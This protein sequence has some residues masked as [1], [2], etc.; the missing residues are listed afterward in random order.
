MVETVGVGQDEVDVVRTAEVV[1]V[2]LVPGMGDDIQS[3]KAGIMEIGDIFVINKADRPDAMKTERE[4]RAVLSLAARDDGWDPPIVQTVATRDQGIDE[5]AEAVEA[6]RRFTDQKGSGFPEAGLPLPAESPGADSRSDGSAGRGQDGSGSSGPMGATN[7]QPGGGPLYSCGSH[8]RA[9]GTE[10]V[11]RR[12]A[13]VGIATRSLE[14]LSRLY[15]D[16]GLEVQTTETVPDQKVRAAILPV[17]DTAV[18]LLEGTEPDSIISRFV[19]KRGEGIH[20]LAL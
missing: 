20:H 12:L 3:I 17:G 2:L 9:I 13:H 1:L 5:V 14:S 15:E 4:I 8:L 19:K 11:I 6:Y 10:K 7:G 18:E 16:L